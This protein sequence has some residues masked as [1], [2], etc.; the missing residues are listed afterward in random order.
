MDN[1]Q[2]SLFEFH[3]LAL[4]L[5]QDPDDVAFGSGGKEPCRDNE[6]TLV[7]KVAVGST[8]QQ[9][10][11]TLV[12]GQVKLIKLM[13]SVQSNQE[14]TNKAITDLS[15]AVNRF[16]VHVDDSKQQKKPVPGCTYCKKWGHRGPCGRGR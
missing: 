15:A 14:Q 12:D 4:R 16:P 3:D 13:E 8:S 5:F 1:P 11:D 6:S 9:A 2:I 7:E 10:L